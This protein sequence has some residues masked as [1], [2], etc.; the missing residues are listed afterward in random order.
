MSDKQQNK[1][2]P[3]M[4]GKGSR[5][6]TF[7]LDS[8]YLTVDMRQITDKGYIDM[9]LKQLKSKLCCYS[10]TFPYLIVNLFGK[11][12]RV[13]KKNDQ[14]MT[15]A[16]VEEWLR[17]FKQFAQEEKAQGVD[18]NVILNSDDP[19]STPSQPTSNPKANTSSKSKTKPKVESEDSDSSDNLK[20]AKKP[21][22]VI[23]TKSKTDNKRTTNSKK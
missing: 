15:L 5:K 8:K 13:A 18:F 17:N 14:Y 16:D 11:H 22:V 1:T 6:Y 3:H 19:P 7:D 10:A 23:K 9:F 2:C 21:I 20:T 4:T 12:T